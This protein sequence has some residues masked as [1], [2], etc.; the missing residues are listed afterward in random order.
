[1]MLGFAARRMG[2]GGSSSTGAKKIMSPWSQF[3]QGIAVGTVGY[4]LGNMLGLPVHKVCGIVGT[5]GKDATK[6]TI[7][8]VFECDESR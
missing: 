5:V 4:G 8:K 7:S 6:S 3:A 2:A 1:M